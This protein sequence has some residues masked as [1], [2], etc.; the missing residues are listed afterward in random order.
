MNF[1]CSNYS[2]YNG[3]CNCYAHSFVEPLPAKNTKYQTVQRSLRILLH[4]YSYSILKCI[5][6]GTG[7]IASAPHKYYRGLFIIFFL[8]LVFFLVIVV[9]VVVVVVS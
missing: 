5:C 6:Y 9:V 7:E 1:I 4:S 2:K 8:L 3:N